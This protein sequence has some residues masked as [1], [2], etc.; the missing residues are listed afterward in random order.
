MSD[1][2]S[3]GRVAAWLRA[4]QVLGI[5]PAAK[6]RCPENAD[7][8]LD[9]IDVPFP[10]GFERYLICPVCHAREAMLFRTRS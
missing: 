4:A 6:V 2:D 7:A 10:G 5:D 8:D 3:E 1:A 9:V